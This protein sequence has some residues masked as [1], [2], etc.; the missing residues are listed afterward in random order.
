LGMPESQIESKATELCLAKDK[1]F[2]A[3]SK[4]ESAPTKMPRWAVEDVETLRR[5]HGTASNAHIAKLLERTTK[6]ITSKANSLGLKKT[7]EHLRQMGK[8]N[9]D[10]RYNR[11]Q[12]EEEEN[13]KTTDSQS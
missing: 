7:S 6:S 13:G 3:S 4:Q 8:D 12:C 9:V 11:E 1:K 10:W 5:M 2:I